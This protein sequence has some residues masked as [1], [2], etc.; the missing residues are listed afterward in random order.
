MI[1]AQFAFKKERGKLESEFQELEC[2]PSRQM[3]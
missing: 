1:S 3:Q 2:S